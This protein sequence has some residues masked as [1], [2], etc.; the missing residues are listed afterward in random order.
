M[1]LRLKLSQQAL[2]IV[3]GVLTIYASFIYFQ[4][5]RPWLMSFQT[6]GTGANIDSFNVVAADTYTYWYAAYTSEWFDV[7]INLLGPVTLYHVLGMHFDLAFMLHVFLFCTAVWGLYRYVKLQILWFVALFLINPSVM[8]QFFVINKEVLMILS[9]LYMQCYVYSERYMHI[10]LAL[11]LAAFAKP[12]F[13]ALLIMFIGLRKIKPELRMYILI[14]LITIITIFYRNMP[15]MIGYNNVLLDGQTSES[16]GI[17]VAL[18]DLAT[19][20]YLYFII[21]FPRLLLVVYSGGFVYATF[22]LIAILY[23]IAKQRLKQ[24]DDMVFLFC[25]YLIM[26]SVVP[27]PQFRYILPLYPLLL[28]LNLRTKKLVNMKLQNAH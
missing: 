14:G 27:F 26:V 23:A 6:D 4:D 1:S 7:P 25:L 24:S 21:I 22:F 18:Q 9:L 11:I 13:L 2:V 28:C 17:T 15:N 10:A 19:N 20:Y 12:E 16:L 3:I 8:G 5:I